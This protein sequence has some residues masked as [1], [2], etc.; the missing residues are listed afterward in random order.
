MIHREQENPKEIIT[1]ILLFQNNGI[2]F[3][4]VTF[5]SMLLM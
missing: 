3:I 5:V 1:V 4:K 2:L